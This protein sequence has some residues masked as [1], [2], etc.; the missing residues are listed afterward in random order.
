MIIKKFFVTDAKESPGSVY[1]VRPWI[2]SLFYKRRKGNIYSIAFSKSGRLY[3]VNANDNRIYVGFKI[4]WFIFTIG[5]YTHNTYIRDIAMDSNGNI[6]FSEASGAGGDGKIYKLNLGPFGQTASIF[7][8]IKLSDVGG[9]WAGDFAFDKQ[10]NLYI[11][12]GNRIPSSI[13]RFRDG[14]RQERT[15]EEIFRDEN[16]PIKGLAFLS[17]DLLCY[18]NWR[19]EIYML[20]IQSGS[21]SIVYSNP[22]HTWL[23]D[24]AFFH[25]SIEEETL[26]EGIKDYTCNG[27]CWRADGTV[28]DRWNLFFPNIDVDDANIQSLLSSIGLPTERTNDDNEIWSRVK[29][30]WSWLHDHT[31]GPLDPNYNDVCN[32]LASLANFPSIAQYAYMFTAYGGF[33]WGSH[34]NED[35]DVV[36]VCTCMCRAHA[37]ATLLYKVGIPP[38]RIAIAETRWRLEYSQHMYVVLRLGCHWYYIDP[39]VSIPELNSTPENVGSGSRDYVHPNTLVLLP[40][41]TL[42]KPMLVR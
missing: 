15:W 42:T 21:R 24:I 39:S 9:S 26:Y 23:S 4:F 14:M 31:L 32:Y 18:A 20:D 30:V 27:I 33:C 35:G 11:S 17:C 1:K 28:D 12:N 13:W 2:E 6:Y 34:V 8:E 3:F 7:Q 36:Y 37:L 29:R 5:V 22:I 10:D 38:D 25:P 16:E 40:G 41:S 19:S